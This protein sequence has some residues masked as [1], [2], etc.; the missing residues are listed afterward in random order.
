MHTLL[1]QEAPGLSGKLESLSLEKRR[2]A[3]ASGCAVV[4]ESLRDL[5]PQARSLVERLLSQGELTADDVAEA[6]ALADAADEQYFELQERGQRQKALGP[7][8]EA[9]LM[10]AIATGFGGTSVN[11]TADALYELCKACDDPS[12]VI[13]S[14]EAAIG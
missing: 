13:R 5:T 9:R 12:P 6:Q 10:A 2:D 11:A 3:I 7:F 1:D 8:S 14:I 4:A